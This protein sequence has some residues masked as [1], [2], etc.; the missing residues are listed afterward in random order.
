MGFVQLDDDRFFRNK[1]ISVSPKTP[2]PP[3]D[4][5]A[6]SRSGAA[7]LNFSPWVLKRAN[8]VRVQDDAVSFLVAQGASLCQNNDRRKSRRDEEQQRER[9]EHLSRRR[10]RSFRSSSSFQR[11]LSLSSLRVLSRRRGKKTAER[12][13]RVVEARKSRVEIVKERKGKNLIFF[14]FFL[15][16][17]SKGREATTLTTTPFEHDALGF[18]PP[19]RLAALEAR[20]ARGCVVFS[21]LCRAPGR[22]GDLCCRRSRRRV[23]GVFFGMP[24]C[25][26]WPPPPPRPSNFPRPFVPLVRAL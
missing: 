24:A 11:P 12:E 5:P 2:P 19:R 21:G 6:L 10:H 18:G 14:Y 4:P 3:S 8:L 1:L 15:Y 26:C 13:E 9:E 16:T 22:H 17:L 7:A 20:P 25:K 23:P